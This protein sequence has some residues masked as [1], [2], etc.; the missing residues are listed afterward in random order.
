MDYAQIF[1]VWQ[2]SDMNAHFKKCFKDNIDQNLLD[3]F[4]EHFG[5]RQDESIFNRSQKIV[6]ISHSSALSI[7]SASAY[8]K[9]TGVD[10]EEYYYLFYEIGGR[11]FLSFQANSFFQNQKGTAGSIPVKNTSPVLTL[12]W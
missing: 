3:K 5:Y 11:T 2:Y 8:W 9:A 6:V 7:S 12:T 4:E 1:S 10:I